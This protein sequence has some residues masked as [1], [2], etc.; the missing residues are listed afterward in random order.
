MF[1]NITVLSLGEETFLLKIFK[2]LTNPKLLKG[3]PK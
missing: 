2:N 3:V 1:N